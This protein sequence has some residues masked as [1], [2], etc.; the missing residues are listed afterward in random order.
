MSATIEELIAQ[1]KPIPI[2]DAIGVLLPQEVHFRRI[3]GLVDGGTIE[4]V[5]ELRASRRALDA[6]LNWRNW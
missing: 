6:Q 3:D 2:W 4:H 5:D 1:Y